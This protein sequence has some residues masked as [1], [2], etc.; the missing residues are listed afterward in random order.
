MNGVCMVLCV[1]R[2]R[3]SVYHL[4]GGN[5]Y[6]SRLDL[7]GHPVLHHVADFGHR[8]CGEWNQ[9][10]GCCAEHT[11]DLAAKGKIR[12]SINETEKRTCNQVT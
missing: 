3:I 4:P 6:T 9:R 12:K 8:Q 10:H 11:H 1:Y 7:L 5:F 2:G